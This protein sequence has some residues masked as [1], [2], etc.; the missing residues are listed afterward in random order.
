[1]AASS[2]VPGPKA[3][4]MSPS[5]RWRLQPNNGGSYRGPPVRQSTRWTRQG[6]DEGE[7][8]GRLPLIV[9]ANEEPDYGDPRPHREGYFPGGQ[10]PRPRDP[11]AGIA[12]AAIRGR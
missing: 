5:Y 1:M 3:A 2:S 10:Y 8:A 11:A 4:P 9:Y 6:S 7:T 12:C